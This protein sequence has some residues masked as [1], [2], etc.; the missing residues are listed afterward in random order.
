M[1]LC[2]EFGGAS[3]NMKDDIAFEKY[4]QWKWSHVKS[5]KTFLPGPEGLLFL[6]VIPVELSQLSHRAC[7]PLWVSRV[8]WEFLEQC[9]LQVALVHGMKVMGWWH[10]V[11][12]TGFL[13]WWCIHSIFIFCHLCV[14]CCWG[15]WVREMGWDRVKNTEVMWGL[16]EDC[17]EY[18]MGIELFCLAGFWC[19][20]GVNQESRGTQH[21]AQHLSVQISV[22]PNLL[23]SGCPAELPAPGSGQCSVPVHCAFT[24]S[25]QA[26]II[27]LFHCN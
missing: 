4:F 12:G 1:L 6:S 14:F 10:L 9:S 26:E 19:L 16:H 20:P 5:N 15:G 3:L 18:S 13:K 11:K 17:P 27:S 8:Y 21:S 25:A 7:S 2:S 23:G 22:N 24:S